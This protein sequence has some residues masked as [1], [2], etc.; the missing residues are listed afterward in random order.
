MEWGLAKRRVGSWVAVLAILWSALAPTLSHALQS[1]GDALAF[2]ICSAA[3]PRATDPGDRSTPAAPDS[4]AGSLEH[5]PYCTLHL[6]TATPPPVA[7]KV[8]LLP[9]RFAAP[10]P[11]LPA[12][13][14]PAAWRHAPPRGPPL[15]A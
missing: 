3:G 9:L 5:C 7:V 14:P 1:Q 4:L 8:A 6:A 10:Q 12:T 13:F 11:V 2:E 15:S